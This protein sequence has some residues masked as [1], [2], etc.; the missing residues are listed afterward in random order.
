VTTTWSASDGPNVSE[1]GLEPAVAIGGLAMIK[2][3]A[4]VS[5]HNEPLMLR[6][7]VFL[8]VG[9]NISYGGGYSV[10]EFRRVGKTI[11]GLTSPPLN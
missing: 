7:N 11:E 4:S 2:P 9:G 5:A 10:H 3:A 6:S 8:T 1:P